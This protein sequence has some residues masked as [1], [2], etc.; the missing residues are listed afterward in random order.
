VRTHL[1]ALKE[2]LE[3]LPYPVYV[4]EVPTAPESYPYLVLIPPV[5]N[6]DLLS[7]CETRQTI[8]DLF[9]VITAGLTTEAVL[10]VLPRVRA[11]LVDAEPVV[12][13]YR[14]DPI[15]H[16]DTR[17]VT[18]DRE[19]RLDTGFVKFSTSRFRYSANPL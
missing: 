8:N 15:R 5:G 10:A 6:Y 14:V 17:P 12:P 3:P 13:G 16:V 1:D 11:A 7:L 9:D 18:S 4:T 19:V 2:L